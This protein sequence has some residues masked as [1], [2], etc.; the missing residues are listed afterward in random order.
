MELKNSVISS[1]DVVYLYPSVPYEWEKESIKKRWKD[2][3]SHTKM[4]LACFMKGLD[5]LMN[6]LYFHFNKIYY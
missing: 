6:S 5:V 1:F 3:K 4:T 2:I